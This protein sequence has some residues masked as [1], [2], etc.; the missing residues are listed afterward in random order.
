MIQKWQ[1]TRPPPVNNVPLRKNTLKKSDLD[2][3]ES[4]EPPRDN[5]VNR[6]DPSL[7]N[8]CLYGWNIRVFIETKGKERRQRR[9]LKKRTGACPQLRKIYR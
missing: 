3:T 8:T 1:P 2:F 7:R 4:G 6:F 5:R 9:V